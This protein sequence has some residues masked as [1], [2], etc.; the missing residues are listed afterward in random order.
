MPRRRPDSLILRQSRGYGYARDFAFCRNA[1]TVLRLPWPAR[2]YYCMRSRN[3][4]PYRCAT[5]VF[6]W[7]QGHGAVF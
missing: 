7:Y 6:G 5:V 2:I 1:A 3:S 4:S